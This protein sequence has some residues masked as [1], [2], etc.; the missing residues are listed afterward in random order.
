MQFLRRFFS[1][2]R[3]IAGDA[4][5]TDWLT[6]LFTA[7]LA[8]FTWQLA[9]VASRQTAILASTDNAL[10]KSADAA[11][12]ASV[13]VQKA[14]AAADAANRLNTTVQRPWVSGM[15]FVAE[16]LTYDVNGARISLGFE[17]SN[18]G[19]SPAQNVRVLAEAFQGP[20]DPGPARKHT[21]DRGNS[22]LGI[23]IFPGEKINAG[24]T[25]YISHKQLGDFKVIAPF[26]MVCILY[27]SSLYAQQYHHSPL[28]V[29]VMMAKAK[30]GRG[31]CGIIVSDGTI[32]VEDLRAVI[33]P[34][35]VGYAD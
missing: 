8:A 24:V 34:L 22:I 25:T 7:A 4:K 32:P 15:P 16:P 21:C 6:V 18:T 12:Q 9:T 35:S 27:Q 10:H 3:R 2:L 1:Q 29:Q 20:F 23:P 26:V 30:Q 33:F 13:A 5:L 14:A 11:A 19:H 17:L 31:C 28:I